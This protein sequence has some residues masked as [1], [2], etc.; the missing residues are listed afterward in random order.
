MIDQIKTQLFEVQNRIKTAALRVNRDPKEITLVAVTKTRSIEEIEAVIAAGVEV[1]GENRVQ[2]AEEK[3]PQLPSGTVKKHL[4]GHLQTNK[5]NKA[6]DLFSFFH[7]VD[8][9]RLAEGISKRAIRRDQRVDV[10]IEVNTSGETS[11]Y[12][13]NPDETIDL[14]QKASVLE[15]IHICG[16][17]TIGPFVNEAEVIRPCF[18][19]LRELRD[20]VAALHLPTVEMKHLSMGMTNDFEIAI[21]EGATLV[22]IGTAIFGPRREH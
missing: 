20:K 9:Y 2:E 6:L 22:R 4:I 8:S 7:S 19:Q 16:L 18:V 3:F 5:I 1:I 15:G 14:I 17:M 11:K 21:E 10:L 12:G 13:A